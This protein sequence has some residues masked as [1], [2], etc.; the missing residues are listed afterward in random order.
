MGKVTFWGLANREM[1][2][3]ETLNSPEKV[4]ALSKHR[5]EPEGFR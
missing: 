2:A 1:G 3:K 5:E 4:G